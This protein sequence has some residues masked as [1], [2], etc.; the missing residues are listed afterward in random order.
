MRED[1]PA[2]VLDMLRIPGVRRERVR[3]LYKEIGIVSGAEP[4]NEARNGRLGT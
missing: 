2:G 3:K 4:E 1:L